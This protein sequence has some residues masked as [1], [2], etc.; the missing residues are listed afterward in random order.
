[1]RRLALALLALLAF[2]SALV[3]SLPAA[4]DSDWGRARLAALAERATR[5][6]PAS[7][8]IEGLSGDPL[9]RL[10]ARRIVVSDRDGPWLEVEGAELAWSPAALW[11]R[12][13]E[14]ASLEA[15]RVAL[16]RLP[17]S[18]GGD[19]Q[20]DGA[21]PLDIVL[22]LFSVARLEVSP[23]LAG[24]APVA[25]LRGRGGWT[26]AG[27]ELELEAQ[28]FARP[29][30]R[31]ALS[32]RGDA[33]GI[34]A[35]A[36]L[37]QAAEGWAARRLGIEGAPALGL[38][39]SAS[40]PRAALR[41]ALEAEAGA[42]RARL[43]GR[44]DLQAM[45]GEL[46]AM[47]ATAGMAPAPD[48]S[49]RGLRVEATAS[50]A[51]RAPLL[52]GR[53]E[54]AG[55]RAG[56]LA[57]AA[58]ALSAT[59][60]ARADGATLELR[61]RAE[62]PALDGD[63]AS[64]PA[65][66]PLD[67][68]LRLALGGEG[69]RIEA[70]RIGHRLFAAQGTGRLGAR[71]IEASIEVSVPQLA[72][73]LAALGIEARGALAAKLDIAGTLDAPEIAAEVRA[74]GFE[75][76]GVAGALLGATPRA[77][78][79]LLPGGGALGIAS[80]LLEGAALRAEGAG[81]VARDALEAR[82]DARLPDG[83][84][85]GLGVTGALHA[86]ATI[87]G[88]PGDVALDIALGSD[89]LGREGME[90]AALRARAALQGLPS[91]PAG[92]VALEGR[93]G[94][95]PVAAALSGA[96]DATGG[97]R[98]ALERLDFP[99]LW[100]EGMAEGRGLEPGRARIGMQAR[101]LAPAGRLLGLS[102]GGEARL[103]A[104]AMP[105][106][107]GRVAAR[108]QL[109]GRNVAAEGLRAATLELRAALAD[110]AGTPILQELRAELSGVPLAGEAATLR[111]QAQGPAEALRATLS[112]TAPS[113]R[114]SLQ[115]SI[116]ARPAPAAT[117][118]S[119]ELVLRGEA[120]RLREPA[121]LA[122]RDGLA[123][124]RL[125]VAAGAGTIAADGRIAATGAELRVAATRVPLA[126]LALLDPG[127]ALDGAVDGE[128]RLS[129]PLASPAGRLGL[130]ADGLR[131]REGAAAGLAP[132]QLRLDADIARGVAR[133]D[134][135]ATL[136]AA[137]TLRASGTVPLDA[138]G[139]LALRVSGAV[140]LA[141]AD[142][143]LSPAGRRARGKATLEATLRG[144]LAAPALSGR[145]ALADGLF[146]D[147]LQGLRIDQ[148]AGEAR[149]EGRMAEAISLRGR[150]GEGE[151]IL[152]GRAPLD[153]RAGPFDL[154]LAL[155]KAR[156]VQSR[157]ATILGEA[158]LSLSGRLPEGLLL[159]GRL[160]IPRA[161]FRLSEPLP[162][163]LPRVEVREA[164][165]GPRRVP[166]RATT[167]SQG[168]PVLPAILRLAVDVEMPDSV[169]LRGRGVEAQAGGTLAL[170]GSAASPDVTGEIALRRGDFTLVGQRL[171]FTR[172]V[173]RFDGGSPS[174]PALDFEA[175]REANGVTAKVQLGGRP[176]APRLQLSSDPEMPPDEVLARLMFGRSVAELSPY[177]LAGIAGGVA[178]M[179]VDT[180][181]SGAMDRLRGTLG[182]DQLRLSSTRDGEGVGV[183]AGRNLAP[184]VYVGVR[185]GR[186][187]G[188][189]DAT[190]Q[191]EVAPR[192]R[193]ETDVGAAATGRVGVS[194]ELDY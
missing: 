7:L 148:V 118:Q 65:S 166:R 27:R 134:A 46:E 185:P 70:A 151:A 175:R 98:L 147:V 122:W 100:A 149:L 68:T 92:R 146:E 124:E 186:E 84:L 145:V 179:F 88:R 57:V 193:V 192:L 131:L 62:D 13:L 111:L 129:G 74:E 157:S 189:Y 159:A 163:S 72:G 17:A 187:P 85:R 153:P 162:A 140:D 53:A 152:T 132:G 182:L 1:M 139:A 137:A 63:E 121:R 58:L 99:G 61:A 174:D 4:L 28:D 6:G 69:A 89:A 39:G 18:G 81:R 180:P 194:W 120:F 130:R 71:G 67:A 47:L 106:G 102:L 101:D 83:A 29:S 108:L 38:R 36:T 86:E 82:I 42:A 150:L 171:D 184:G 158:S 170:R 125:R 154:A 37:S 161:E 34:E 95:A 177:E 138:G 19:G 127:L 188:T 79:M 165:A 10:A 113:A 76:P 191:V 103:E 117:I 190:V 176:S 133:V 105:E 80:F 110:A 21:P 35:R 104:E 23:A 45:R 155:R 66:S 9:A 41:V 169:F 73:P 141:L 2:A 94:E 16:L 90:V 119:A 11:R 135:D 43:S 56:P 22:G 12:R 30:D 115:A 24:E 5:D 51:L 59:G 91:S 156:L 136:G 14:V 77:E 54:A 3:L 50:G 44:L 178:T 20:E 144:S 40:G 116:A 32:L 167:A 78:A 126:L 107:D 143:L 26:A 48:I 173:A 183:E 112:A 160:A 52:R 128:L 93:V 15:R 172:G 25:A 114:A 64:R 96:R 142:P 75:A 60:D 49:W 87:G 109:S 55:L 31:L 8:A 168:P 97:W 181:G 33:S 164:G 123:I